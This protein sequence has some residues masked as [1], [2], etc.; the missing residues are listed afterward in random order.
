MKKN[1]SI[2][3]TIALVLLVLPLSLSAM[4]YQHKLKVENM[5]MTFEWT[6][7]KEKIHVQ[8]SAKTTGWVGIGFSPEKAMSGANIIIG[9]VKNGKATIEDH[10]GHR[11]TNHKNDKELGGKNHVLNPS[12]KETGGYTTISFTLLLKIN[13]EYDKPIEP[14]GSSTILLAYGSGKDS[15]KT[16]HSYRRVYEINLSTGENKKIK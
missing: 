10:Y 9:Y 7:E 6:L 13:D 4:E 2:N 14:D 1:V 5:A 16:R 8:L 12:G 15:F 11:N 3:L